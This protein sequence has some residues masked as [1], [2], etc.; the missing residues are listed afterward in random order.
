MEEAE[1][2]GLEE[3]EVEPAE[4]EEPEET[5]GRR[6]EETVGKKY[7]RR[8]VGDSWRKR[9]K[10]RNRRRRLGRSTI[11]GKWVTVGGNGWEDY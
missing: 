10:R 5:V 8:E 3:M 11:G 1:E 4:T 6:V 7:N 2:V 9:R